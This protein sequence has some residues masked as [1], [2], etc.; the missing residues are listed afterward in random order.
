MLLLSIKKTS[1]EL[2]FLNGITGKVMPC[3]SQVGIQACGI[4][5]QANHKALIAKC[6]G[7]FWKPHKKSIILMATALTIAKKIF[8]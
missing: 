8:A 1:R 4:K 3:V 6:I 2:T 7:C 5:E